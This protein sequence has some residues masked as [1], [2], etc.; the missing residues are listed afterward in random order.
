MSTIQEIIL[1]DIGDFEEVEII[2]IAVSA[3]DAVAAEDTLLTLESDKA[4]MDIPCPFAGVVQRVLVRQGDRISK[5]TPLV[6]LDVAAPACGTPS[7]EAGD[8]GPRAEAPAEEPSPQAPVEAAQ[9][10]PPD[11]RLIVSP[12]A[13]PE[14]EAQP[15][16]DAGVGSP[17]AGPSVR[18]FARELGVDLAQVT[19]TGPRGR[20]TKDDVKAFVKPVLS[21]TASPVAPF[22]AALPDSRQVDF[23]KFGPISTQAMSRIKRRS[24]QNLSR[25]WISVPHVTQFD[26]ADITELSAF[27]RAQREESSSEQDVKLTLLVFVIKAVATALRR[28]PEFC[29][30][31]SPDG[32]HLILKDYCHIGVAV[33]TESGL[34]VPVIRDV[35]QKGLID[36]ARSLGTVSVQARAGKLS[37]EQLQG[38]CFTVSSLGG[39]GGRQFTPIINVP[40]VA[41][42]GVSRAETKPVWNGETF[43]PRSILPFALSYDHRAIDGVSGAQFTRFLA[44]VLSDIRRILL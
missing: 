35:D 29:A 8:V 34:L 36:I 31:L 6:Q 9:A 16:R 13:D 32:E 30:S 33:N 39:V 43:V 41:I 22:H 28:Y 17:H 38:G 26:E 20:I 25:N 23:S 4:S 1:P 14:N 44:T 3:G 10:D 5:G 7:P 12:A 18:R 15:G 24:G 27:Q 21:G 40:E 42:L 2:D 37:P 19:G 11:P